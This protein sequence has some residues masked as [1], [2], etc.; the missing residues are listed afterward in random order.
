MDGRILEDTEYCGNFY[1][2]P[3]DGVRAALDAGHDM[4]LEIEVEGAAQVKRIF[5]DAV[6]VMLIPPDAA[7]LEA[8]LRGRG[9]ESDE[10]VAL[11]MERA[12]R[13]ISVSDTYD[14]IVVSY[15]GDADGCAADLASILRAEKLKQ[16]RMRG[17]ADSFFDDRQPNDSLS[18][19]TI[20]D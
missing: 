11:R 20:Q 14:Y 16:P 18:S 7:T 2:T 1:G 19:V 10:V 12:R 6:S 8:R 3:A 13:E 15:D 9:T 5:P 4:V 17:Y